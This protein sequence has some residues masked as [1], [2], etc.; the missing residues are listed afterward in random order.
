MER[1]TAKT[2]VKVYAVL[3]FI[4]GV[5]NVVAALGLL[6]GGA[7]LAAMAGS[8]YTR[9]FAG[10]SVFLGVLLLIMGAVELY[11]GWGLWTFKNWARITM[12]VVSVLSLPNFPLGTVIGVVGIYLFGFNEDVKR[13]FGATHERGSR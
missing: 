10:A 12:I 6:A 3:A 4:G 5:L 13:L 8:Q 9:L 7:G 11:A 1:D 2:I